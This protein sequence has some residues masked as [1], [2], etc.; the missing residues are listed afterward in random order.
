MLSNN[1]QQENAQYP[2]IFNS[3]IQHNLPQPHTTPEC[4][5]TNA[6]DGGGKYDALQR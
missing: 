3:L 1:E 4:I 6:G 5:S 2:I